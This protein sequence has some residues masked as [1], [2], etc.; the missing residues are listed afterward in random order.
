MRHSLRRRIILTVIPFLFL[1]AL[2]GAS[3]LFLLESLSRKINAIMRENYDSVRAMEHLKEASIGIDESFRIAL[4][5]DE[6]SALSQF[7]R[8]WSS[9]SKELAIEEQNITIFPEEE[10]LVAELQ[11]LTSRYEK[12]G[13]RFF[14]ERTPDDPARK[15]DYKGSNSNGG[16]AD[17]YGK[18]N[19][20]AEDIRRI[21][22][23]HMEQASRDA[24]QLAR[25][26]IIGFAI[27]LIV[28][29]LL[30]ALFTH[31]LIRAIL[32]PIIAVT[33]AAEAISLG[34]LDR[35]V[36]VLG[37]DEL[38]RLAETFN[39]MSDKLRALRESN[40]ARLLRL[41]ETSQAAIDSF[42]DPILV[43]DPDGYVE[44]ANPAA[45]QVFGVVPAAEE[46]PRRWQPP[47]VL[48][49]PVKDSLELQRPFLT[50]AFGEIVNFRLQS[51]ERSYLPQVRPIRDRTGGT[52]GAAIVLNDV[53]QFRLL[54]QFKTDLVATV[55]HELKTPLTSIRL[56]IHVLLEES[57]G[58]L[59][60]KQV[61]L[62]VDARENT[63]RIIRLVDHLFAL[64]RLQEG[65]SALQLTSQSPALLLRHLADSYTTRAEDKR[66][67]VI[68]DAQ[69]NLPMIRVDPVRFEHALGNLMNNALT[70]TDSGGKITLK[71]S[72]ENGQILM[73]ISDTGIGIPASHLPKVF[74]RFFR[75]PGQSS[76]TGTGL[77]LA[78]VREIVRAHGGEIVC[79]SE[80]ER[81]TSFTISL[82]VEERS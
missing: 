21:N 7:T 42:P 19:K 12:D 74:N 61:E 65:D 76:P 40:T 58:P 31:R 73:S 6:S 57:I 72:H 8:A 28:I 38:A 52:L 37:N 44:L 39:A 45:R 75:V 78:I 27:G 17:T 54:D 51:E 46:A 26:F 4:E 71:A 80:P 33:M 64:A 68:V 79:R 30:A 59:L 25:T 15:L 55:S 60:S 16:L 69:D 43:I 11:R 49:Q 70:Y 81:G 5:G 1:L 56:A 82:P 10:R 24:R 9:Y 3:S 48:R 50:R 53:T 47:D 29:A 32:R 41:Q 34:R 18:I 63:E 14:F 20:V 67:T 22:Q 23:E 77:G 2:M 13:N 35:T 62:L 36:P 66:L